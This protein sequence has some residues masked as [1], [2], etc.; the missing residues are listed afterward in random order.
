[1]I[2]LFKNKPKNE[3]QYKANRRKP[4][5][6]NYSSVS[7][8]RE[9]GLDRRDPKEKQ[10]KN[11]S[12][13]QP[14][15]KRISKLVNYLI[16]AVVVCGFLYMSLLT[17]VAHLKFSG[18]KFYPRDKSSY[19]TGVDKQLKSS[20]L[21]RFKPTFDINKLASDIKQQFPEV[22]DVN[23]SISL[24]RHRPTIELTLA[25]PTAK[26]VTPQT[27]YL[28]DENG[29]ALF[30]QKYASA[31]LDT[32]SLLT[33]NDSSGQGIQPGKPAL[34]AQQFDF[35]REVIG[36]TEAKG[37]KPRSF[38]LSSGGTELDVKFDGISYFVKF[39]FQEDARQSSGAFIALHNQLQRD[40][41]TPSSYVDLRIPDKA[42]VK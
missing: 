27:T 30:E 11:P 17:P 5:I 39:N 20:I 21:Y 25:K 24:F 13:S 37:L 28:L 41:V 38:E 4:P 40:H 26:L 12:K 1:M 3:R 15:L 2:N 22:S 36:Q 19:E 33:I 10:A 32:S 31:N 35:I 18:E 14:V 9:R 8:P 7:Q 16:I 42:F 6:F 34:T 29:I 23:I